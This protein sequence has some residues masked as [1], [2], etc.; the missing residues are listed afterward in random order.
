MRVKLFLLLVMGCSKHKIEWS[1]KKVQLLSKAHL[2][3][4]LLLQFFDEQIREAP[5]KPH[6]LQKQ[7]FDRK[8]ALSTDNTSPFCDSYVSEDHN[9]HWIWTK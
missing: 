9:A 3:W 8:I 4:K 1:L 7:D 5:F 2:K 6:S